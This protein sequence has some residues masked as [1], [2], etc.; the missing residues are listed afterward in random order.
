MEIIISSIALLIYMVICVG[1]YYLIF[2]K[3]HKR[4]NLKDFEIL[5][6]FTN[7]FVTLSMTIIVIF[8]GIQF[9]KE[10]Y[11]NIDDRNTEIAFLIFG[12]LTI[13]GAISNFI[14]FIKRNLKD[15]DPAVRISYEK[16]MMKTAEILEVIIF[17][18]FI[19]MPLWLKV[20]L[21]IAYLD[22]DTALFTKY[23]VA[24]IISPFISVFLLYQLNP[25]DIRT[26]FKKAL[27]K[28]KANGDNGE[29]DENKEKDENNS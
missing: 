24:S 16:R 29:N 19:F 18:L 12:I 25:L 3:H 17:G 28:G 20:P 27:C 8:I 10:A 1:S 11:N 14:F 13:T 21:K 2:N 5:K 4:N 26:K 22:G 23:I 15:L 9:F 6:S 7:Y